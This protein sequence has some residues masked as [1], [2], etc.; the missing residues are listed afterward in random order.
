[1]IVIER[2]TQSYLACCILAAL[3]AGGCS[4]PEIIV[5]HDPLSADEHADLGRAYE[6]QG[7]LDLAAEQYRGALR[8][9]RKHLPS[10]LLL[11]DLSY[12]TGN[13]REAEESY[14]RAM[15][16]SPRDGDIRN[17]LAWIYLQTNRKSDAAQQ[18]AVQALALNPARRAFYLDTLGVALLKLGKAAE[19]IAA[20]RESV[21][22]L[23]PDHP[24]LILQANGHLAEAYRAA[25][26]E[27][28][29]REAIRRQQELQKDRLR[30]RL[31]ERR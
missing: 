9:N 24:E 10:L 30:Q 6:S 17:N 13:Y 2:F 14:G 15:K 5:L 16:F 28:N 19:A 27:I 21:Q 22:T 29:Y 1:M 23:P 12:R 7:K 31:K 18:L 4:L 11:G 26:D 25:G 20:L 8:K 3:L